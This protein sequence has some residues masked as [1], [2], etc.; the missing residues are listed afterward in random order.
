[1]HPVVHSFD[2]FMV[3]SYGL[4]LVLAFLAGIWLARGRAAKVGVDR[5]QI[6]NLCLL[7]LL[8]AVLG[9]RLL[10]VAENVPLY[11]ADPWRVLRLGE[12][13]MSMY[14]GVFLAMAASAAYA[15]FVG[16]SFVQVADVCAPS[17]ALG[18]AVTRVGCFLNGCCFG[19]HCT[20]P[21]AVVFPPASPAGHA[22][23]GTPIHP[24]QLYAAAYSLALFGIL[25]LVSRRQAR[26]G[27]VIGI[28]LLLHAAGRFAL[29]LLRH[30]EPAAT[31][32]V[33]G[34]LAFTSYQLMC[35]CLFSI[36]TYLLLASPSSSE[37]TY[38]RSPSFHHR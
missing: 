12:G 24:T 6:V 27:A 7:I 23:P 5:R 8:A 3:R 35:V 16:L 19:T 4:A 17:L 37:V 29:E 26:P 30:H 20:L 31:P 11:A 32:L 21:W 9:S 25:L 36:G 10:H 28:F 22:F 2:L 18:E 33:V 15:R 38:A 34:D 14:G 13:G 1:M